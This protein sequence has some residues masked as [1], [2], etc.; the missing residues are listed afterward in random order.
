MSSGNGP[1][2]QF[3]ISMSQAQRAHLLQLHLQEHA[4]GK[5]PRFLAAYREII[6]RLQRDPQIFGEELYM[7]PVIRLDIRQAIVDR[8]VV[9]YGVHKEKRIV[10]IQGFKVLS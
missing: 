8:I 5:G 7:L 9:D 3:V 1:P 10:F 2:Q 4:L 6:R